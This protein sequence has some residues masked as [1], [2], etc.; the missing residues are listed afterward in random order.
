MKTIAKIGVL[1]I[2]VFLYS[3][4]ASYIAVRTEVYRGTDL[5]TPKTFRKQVIEM[6]QAT[7]GTMQ[8]LDKV[9]ADPAAA[10]FGRMVATFKFY[11]PS[12]LY[13]TPAKYEKAYKTAIEDKVLKP[14]QAMIDYIV[15]AS[16]DVEGSAA[17]GASDA[18]LRR[19][20]KEL[21]TDIQ[22]LIEGTQSR[23][24]RIHK[25]ELHVY[26]SHI[27]R[28]FEKGRRQAPEVKKTDSE[29]AKTTGLPVDNDAERASAVAFLRDQIRL[30]NLQI[31]ELI[32][33]AVVAPVQSVQSEIA[34]TLVVS[35]GDPNIPII[36]VADPAKWGQYVNDVRS[37]NFFGNSET[38]FRME[39]LG[40]NHIK[41]VLFDPSE[42]T[43]V[44]LNVFSTALRIT[45]AAYG[46]PLPKDQGT[47]TNNA[48]EQQT[49]SKPYI[50]AEVKQ[51]NASRL[52]RGQRMEKY[53]WKVADRA[54]RFSAPATLGS[55]APNGE[56]ADLADL[57]D[58][59]ADEIQNPQT[60]KCGG[61]H[62][63]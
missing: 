13:G 36:I 41:S 23:L 40:E 10:D 48:S 61:T 34:R 53:F 26:V 19:R 57:I 12:D 58:C 42:V 35:L 5:I 24:D 30:E 44:G 11:L 14:Q 21:Q 32:N 52:I 29:L 1:I 3:G 8:K 54:N 49:V 22:K 6:A 43:K 17:A 51:I 25:A 2:S 45:A 20:L 37:T 15:K 27:D 47:Q 7:R 38:A 28:K 59:M 60:V 56:V 62:G 33:G 39:G 55:A 18:D 63:N 31:A 4:C 50:D 16:K 9:V 46:F